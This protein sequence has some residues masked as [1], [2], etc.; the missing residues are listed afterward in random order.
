MSKEAM[1]RNLTNT[2]TRTLIIGL[3]G[4]DWS[5]LQPLLEK[6]LCPNI[7]K[8]KEQ[9][10]WAFLNSTTPPMTLPSWSSMLTGASPG[11][12]GIFDFV[13]RDEGKLKVHFTNST[14]RQVPT[15]HEILSQ[16][17]QRVA[18]IAVPTTWP[19]SK[20]NGVMIS[21]FDSPVSTG[22]DGSFCHPPEVYA[23]IQRRFGGL[24]FADFQESEIGDDWHRRALQL[25]TK[26][27]S[28]KTEIALWLMT[29]E[30]W[31]CLMIL[32]GESD[33]ASHHFWRFHDENSPR[34]PQNCEPYLK[35]A[36]DNI[37]Q[38]LD[39]AVGRL[40]HEA[41]AE[42][43]CICS[44]HGFGGAGSHALFLNRF[45]E[46]KGWLKYKKNRHRTGMRFGSGL[47]DR[48]RSLGLKLIP[49]SLQG[50]VFRLIPD[51]IMNHLESQSRFGNIDIHR[52]KAFSD[53][54]NY[55]ATIRFN[56]SLSEGE[57]QQLENDL[58]NWEVDGHFPIEKVFKREDLYVGDCVNRSP[59]IILQLRLRNGY[60]DT[61]LPSVR[62]HA[63]QTWRIFHPSE[64]QG[65]KGLGMNG[66][67]RQFGIL[68]LGGEAFEHQ[69]IQAGM[70]DIAPTLLHVQNE[71]I[72]YWMDGRVLTEA[73]K[74]DQPVQYSHEHWSPTKQQSPSST[75]NEA[76]RKRLRGLGYL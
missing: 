33:T 55:A 63:G 11:K 2:G 22:I 36:I 10:A 47:S 42:V 24:K 1:N 8:I 5:I 72:P 69:E 34:K 48:L 53:E 66:T 40:L 61:L 46:E 60:T 58:L 6:G 59:E 13:H 64:Y 39:E 70:A 19:P 7:Q 23:E 21:G 26:E 37:Y 43:L 73:L 54:M 25:M 9:G 52:S 31:D 14:D 51:R 76:I 20:V 30:R 38:K 71:A 12:H 65:G 74:Q 28:R 16:R 3:D 29:Q 62:A 49:P 67:H 27:I 32:F 4:A 18:S 45:L 41:N 50:K 56:G 57:V 35:N 44:D 17:G 75:E 68:L 15:I